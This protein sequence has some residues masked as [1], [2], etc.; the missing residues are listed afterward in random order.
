MIIKHLWKYGLCTSDQYS[1]WQ[2][3]DLHGPI[4]NKKSEALKHDKSVP[5]VQ[6][7]AGGF[8]AAVSAPALEPASAAS[9]LPNP[10]GLHLRPTLALH[11]SLN[12]RASCT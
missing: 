7:I 4:S 6:N 8:D 9:D 2:S 11:H 3:H 5:L 10:L 1:Q 12:R